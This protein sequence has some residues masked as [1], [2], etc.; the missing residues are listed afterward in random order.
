[1]NKFTFQTDVKGERF[2]QEI[3]N[4]MVAL[5]KISIEEAIGRINRQWENVRLVGEH[6]VIYHETQDFHAKDIYF[7]HDSKWWKNEDQAKPQP[8]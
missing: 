3:A 5:F 1:M 6:H 7:G 4:E 8:Y 2:C